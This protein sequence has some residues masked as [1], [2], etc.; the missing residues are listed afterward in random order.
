MS[1]IPNTGCVERAQ[2]KGAPAVEE[3]LA[4]GPVHVIRRNRPV[5]VALSRSST[6]SRQPTP[7]AAGLQ[8]LWKTSVPGPRALGHGG[9]PGKAAL[10]SR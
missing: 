1:A 5:F 7:T 10:P 3:R 6:R 4:K 9:R 8:P 2:A